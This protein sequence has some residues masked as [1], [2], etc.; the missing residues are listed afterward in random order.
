[1]SSA[2]LSTSSSQIS[3]MNS[4]ATSVNYSNIAHTLYEG[5][6]LQYVYL[7]QYFQTQQAPSCTGLVRRSH[8]TWLMREFHNAQT[9]PHPVQWHK[10][11]VFVWHSILVYA[12][13]FLNVSSQSKQL[14]PVTFWV[15]HL[16]SGRDRLKEVEAVPAAPSYMRVW[17]LRFGFV[18]ASLLESV[19]ALVVDAVPVKNPWAMCRQKGAWQLIC[20]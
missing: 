2:S 15:P 6:R 4:Q 18:F 7:F 20:F 3:S 8:H 17:V 14:W 13:K 1:M 10:P 19:L 11:P 16:L 12:L 5:L 9:S